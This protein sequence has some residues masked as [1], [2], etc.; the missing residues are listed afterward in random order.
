[1]NIYSK[2]FV[3]NDIK[4]KFKFKYKNQNQKAN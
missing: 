1:M 2:D 3:Q 4:I